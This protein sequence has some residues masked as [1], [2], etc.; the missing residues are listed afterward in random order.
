MGA[1]IPAMLSWA[2]DRWRARQ[3]QT[4]LQTLARIGDEPTFPN[5]V[6]Q[7]CTARQMRAPEYLA[8][9]D[10]LHCDNTTHRKV[11]EYCFVLQALKEQGVLEAG[12]RGVGFGVGKDR[13][14]AALARRGCEVLATDQSRARATEQ[15]WAET[16][17]HAGELSELNAHGIC[18]P[19]EFEALVRFREVDMN[20]IP[21]DLTGFDFTWSACAFEHLGSIEKGLAFV[22]HSLR[23]LK[24]GGVAVH[25]T[26]LNLT[27]DDDTVSEGDTVLFRRRDM[28]ELERRLGAAGHQVLPLNFHPGNATLDHVVDVPPYRTS[29]HL[30]LLIRRYVATSFGIVVRRAPSSEPT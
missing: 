1:S 30:R 9:C 7:A 29:P 5:V 23:C 14:C 6:S 18:P 20:F 3:Q 24:P 8:W 2:K 16:E 4:L 27:S 17:Q 10:E 15:G 19:D 22:E 26:E 28:V 25:T 13:L 11:W 21:D 12:R